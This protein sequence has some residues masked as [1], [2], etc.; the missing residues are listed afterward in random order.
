MKNYKSLL[1][2]IA[3]LFITSCVQETHLKT[4]TFKVDMRG[5]D[6]ITNP[7]VRGQFTSPAW[8][9]LVPLTDENN[10]SIY[11]AKVEFQAA[12]YDIKFKFVNNDEYELQN[13]PNRS[14]K[15]EYEPENFTYEATINNPKAKTTKK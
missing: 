7:G 15:F 10:D 3:I 12:Q 14:I 1:V 8:K 11:E 2:L 13:Q 4:I 9:A 6:N 5:L